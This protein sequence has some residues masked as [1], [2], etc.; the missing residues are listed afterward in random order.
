[1]RCEAQHKADETKWLDQVSDNIF[2]SDASSWSS[3]HAKSIERTSRAKCITALLPLLSNHSADPFMVQHAMR[4]IINSTAYLN[5]GQT[6]VCTAD[7]PLYCLVKQI[8]W[9]FPNEFGPEKLLVLFGDLHL[10]KQTMAVL[11]NLLKDSGW[12]NVLEDAKVLPSGVAESVLSAS[13]IK[14][15]RHAHEVTLAALYVLKKEAYNARCLYDELDFEQWCIKMKEKSVMFYY[16]DLVMQLQ[17]ILFQF[18]KSLRTGNWELYVNSVK[19]LIGWFFIFDHP[20]YAR[21]VSIHLYDIMSR[22]TI[23]FFNQ[24]ISSIWQDIG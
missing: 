12:V 5:P 6:P 1:M 9:K 23:R 13:H 17:Q 15:S 24:Y 4:T 22:C 21:W 10:E 3:Y 11:G 8:Q 14:K 16:W 20:N 19:L 2:S 18:V 7:Q